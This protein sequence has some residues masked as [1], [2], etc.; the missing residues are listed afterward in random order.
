[1]S[2][3]YRKRK[4]EGHVRREEILAAAGEVFLAEGYENTTIRRIAAR[5][6][7]TSAAL[8]LYFSDKDA[9]LLEI[10]DHAFARLLDRFE[11][12]RN[13]GDDPLTVLRRM[14]EAYV[15]FGLDHPDEYRLTFMAKSDMARAGALPFA[16]RT[17]ELDLQAPGGKGP[18]SFALLQSQVAMLID[19]RSLQPGDPGTIA[20]LIWAAGH[21]LVSLLITFPD[22][23]WSDREVL[24]RGSVDLPLQGLIAS[25]PAN[26]SPANSV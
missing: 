11:Q 1:M 14:M 6:G 5:V 8:Y 12:I 13:D 26:G 19:S 2:K 22:F 7:V 17:D 9:I 24:I 16:H 25:R 18:Q 20:E 21:G 3:P 23:P 10:C 15:R 4:G